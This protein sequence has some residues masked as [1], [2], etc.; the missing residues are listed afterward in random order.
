MNIQ[1]SSGK[2]SELKEQA[3][4][5]TASISLRF[6]VRSPTISA[7][8][9]PRTSQRRWN[10]AVLMPPIVCTPPRP[11]LC[12]PSVP[13]QPPHSN[14]PLYYITPTNIWLARSPAVRTLRATSVNSGWAHS[15][16]NPATNLSYR[17]GNSYCRYGPT[18]GNK[19]PQWWSPLI[20]CS[21]P[22]PIMSRPIAH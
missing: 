11:I 21:W 20:G 5:Y 18:I 2:A 1:T 6:F 12:A 3:E 19:P 14:N 8:S 17:A 9:C 16:S 13:H 15:N 7:L 10:I 22:L 4:V